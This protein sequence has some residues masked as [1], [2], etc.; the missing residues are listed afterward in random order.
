MNFTAEYIRTSFDEQSN[1]E[2]TLKLKGYQSKE[3][4]NSFEKEKDYRFSVSEVKS[5]RTIEQNKLMWSVIHEIAV[6]RS[7]ERANDDWDIYIEALERAGAKYTYISVV[8]EAVDFVKEQFR[9]VKEA[10]QYEYNGHTFQVL[11][12]YIGSSKMDTKEMTKLVDTVLD[13]ASEEGIEIET[14]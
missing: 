2:I 5:A 3:I 4:T 11:K 6:A 10:N 12:C 14:R 1:K 13:I 8:P 9:A 7:G